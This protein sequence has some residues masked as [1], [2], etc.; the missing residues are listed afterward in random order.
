MNNQSNAKL[1]LAAILN[2]FLA[3]II[4]FAVGMDQGLRATP[5]FAAGALLLIG[6]FLFVNTLN[7]R[8]AQERLRRLANIRSIPLKAPIDGG[9]ANV[10]RIASQKALIVLAKKR[11]R[12]VLC[13]RAPEGLSFY[14]VPLQEA[15]YLYVRREK[16]QASSGREQKPA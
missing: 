12:E 2:L 14:Y 11:G 9:K 7:D 10:I 13:Y 6:I 15:V 1:V 4:L 16:P 8:A 5:L 3:F